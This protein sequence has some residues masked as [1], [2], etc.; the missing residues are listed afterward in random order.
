MSYKDQLEL[1]SKLTIDS[2]N[3]TAA[4]IAVIGQEQYDKIKKEQ[5]NASAIYYLYNVLG[6]LVPTYK[7]KALKNKP[8]KERVVNEIIKGE[9]DLY[10]ELREILLRTPVKNLMATIRNRYEKCGAAIAEICHEDETLNKLLIHEAECEHA[11][12]KHR[13]D[14]NSV[15]G[16]FASPQSFYDATVHKAKTSQQPKWDAKVFENVEVVAEGKGYQSTPLAQSIA[17]ANKLPD[18]PPEV[19]ID[20]AGDL[21]PIDVT[22]TDIR[23]E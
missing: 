13:L 21:H 3:A 16:A 10:V 1:M 23:K 12:R 11:R 2:K 19:N 20:V 5:R 22:E 14:M 6:K 7:A 15:S 17:E 9:D 8:M 4:I 18:P